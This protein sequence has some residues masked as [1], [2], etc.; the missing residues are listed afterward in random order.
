MSS[1]KQREDLVNLIISS[2]HTDSS[3]S[4]TRQSQ[5]T[6][7]IPNDSDEFTFLRVCVQDMTI[8][9]GYKICNF[10]ILGLTDLTESKTYKRKRFL[11]QRF[12]VLMLCL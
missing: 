4:I 2:H 8:I 1:T 12:H 10:F 6:N 5:G 7:F 3:G 11:S 9:L